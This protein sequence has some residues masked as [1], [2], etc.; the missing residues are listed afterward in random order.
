MTTQEFLTH[1]SDAMQRDEALSPEMSLDSLEEWDSLAIISLISLYEH[2]FHISL[3]SNA[4]KECK[5]VA[6][7]LAL[8]KDKLED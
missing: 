3:T 8:A 1:L 6:D 5:I 7:L 4:L 2:L